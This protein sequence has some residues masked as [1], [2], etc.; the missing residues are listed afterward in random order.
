MVE[1]LGMKPMEAIVSAT[2]INSKAVGAEDK[3]GTLEKGKLA[4]LLVLRGNP[5]DDISILMDKG[6][7]QLIMKEGE[8]FRKAD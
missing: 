6:N 8:I 4:D 3:I 1:I 2:K 5:L 7:I